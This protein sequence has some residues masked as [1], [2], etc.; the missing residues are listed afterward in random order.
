MDLNLRRVILAGTGSF[1]PNAPVPTDRIDEVLG[2]IDSAP[3]KVRT[4]GARFARKFAE[5]SGVEFR[6]FAIDPDTKQMTHNVASL[7]EV[8]CRKALETARLG[9]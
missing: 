6:H 2:T 4:F 9:L 5:R 3:E 1:L 7:A 8:A